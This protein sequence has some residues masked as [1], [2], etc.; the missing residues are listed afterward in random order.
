MGVAQGAH[1]YSNSNCML[2][3]TYQVGDVVEAE[4]VTAGT[5]VT[6]CKWHYILL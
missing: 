1:N 6:E 4:G 2:I 5:T 3:Q